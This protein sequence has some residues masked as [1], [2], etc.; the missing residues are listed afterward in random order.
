MFPRPKYHV[1]W[2][3][4][5]ERREDIRAAARTLAR[6]LGTENHH[7]EWRDAGRYHQQVG[8]APR[9]DPRRFSTPPP[10]S[11][12]RTM[13]PGR[14]RP[15]SH[16]I[17]RPGRQPNPSRASP[18]DWKSRALPRRGPPVAAIHV[19]RRYMQEGWKKRQPRGFE[20]RGTLR[21]GPERPADDPR[22]NPRDGLCGGP[23]RS[24]REP[25]TSFQ[26]TSKHKTSG[27]EG[28]KEKAEKPQR[29]II[30]TVDEEGHERK[31]GQLS[32]VNALRAYRFFEDM[33]GAVQFFLQKGGKRDQVQAEMRLAGGRR[34]V[35]F[36]EKTA[37]PP[38]GQEGGDGATTEKLRCKSSARKRSRPNR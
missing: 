34:M 18:W 1:Q 33:N 13:E 36:E 16:D 21:G 26:T 35:W 32:R 19:P 30:I 5:R 9:C 37:Q 6:L 17:P 27:G 7:N 4:E 3:W 8:W 11:F 24:A 14:W 2:R 29:P 25:Q 31:W 10:R 22:R 23:A 12:Q 38:R 15:S 20:P 28:E